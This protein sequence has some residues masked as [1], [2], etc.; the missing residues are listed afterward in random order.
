MPY[1]SNGKK[2]DVFH[3]LVNLGKEPDWQTTKRGV[4]YHEFKA[5]KYIIRYAHPEARV[6]DSLLYYGL[7]DAVQEICSH[8]NDSLEMKV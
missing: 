3:W 8:P 1:S 5:G 7:I 6:A 4:E 2:N